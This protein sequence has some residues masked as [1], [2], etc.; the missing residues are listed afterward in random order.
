MIKTLLIWLCMCSLAWG[1]GINVSGVSMSG[2][3]LC[4]AKKTVLT[5]GDSLTF[6]TGS[7]NSWSYRKFLQILQSVA[8]DFVGLYDDPASDPDYSVLHSGIPGYNTASIE[9]T[10]LP[11]SLVFFTDGAPGR[12]IIIIHAGTNDQLQTSGGREGARDNIEDMI[13]LIDVY[14]PGIDVYISLIAPAEIAGTYLYA[15]VVTF[16]GILKTMLDTYKVSKSNLYYADIHSAFINDTYSFCSGDWYANCMSND[17]HPND[18]GYE[19]MA[20]QYNVCIN[21]PSGVNCNGN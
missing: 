20:N 16:N 10:L 2:V 5:V 8:F 18:N 19:T 12:S 21:N 3:D 1:A 9:A 6:G 14:N 15:D 7:T 4:A 13:D 11:D 17:S